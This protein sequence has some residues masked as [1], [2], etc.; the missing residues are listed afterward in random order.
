MSHILIGLNE[1]CLTIVLNRVDKKNALT[2]DMYQKMADAIE[3]V[4][5]DGQQSN[6][7]TQD[8]HELGP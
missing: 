1:Q 3:H 6:D 8:A 4:K 2:R 7:E 5:N